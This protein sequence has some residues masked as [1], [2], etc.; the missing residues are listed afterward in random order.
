MRLRS[1]IRELKQQHAQLQEM[2]EAQQLQL[3]ASVIGAE[4]ACQEAQTAACNC[5]LARPQHAE[6]CYDHSSESPSADSAATESALE[7]MTDTV[8]SDME[9]CESQ[10]SSADSSQHSMLLH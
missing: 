6:A 7:S 5:H 9:C 10:H 4:S 3:Q 8:T 1:K 2:K